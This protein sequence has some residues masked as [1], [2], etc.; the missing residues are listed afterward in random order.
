MSLRFEVRIIS[1]R[2]DR[3]EE[4]PNL[5]DAYKRYEEVRD[6]RTMEVAIYD[7]DRQ[8]LIISNRS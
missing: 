7:L 1:A 2:E 5:D 4:Y 6:S 3:V 8:E